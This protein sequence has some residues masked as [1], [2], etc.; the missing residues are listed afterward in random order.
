MEEAIDTA[1]AQLYYNGVNVDEYLNWK[2]TVEK[3]E[4]GPQEDQDSLYNPESDINKAPKSKPGRS[5]FF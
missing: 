3:K 2:D 1:I 4:K 5:Y